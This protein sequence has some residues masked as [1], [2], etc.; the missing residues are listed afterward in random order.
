MSDPE[1]NVCLSGH[2]ISL[3]RDSAQTETAVSLPGSGGSVM[4]VLPI[5][6]W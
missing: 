4:A 6:L 3:P 2:F 1:V 5:Q